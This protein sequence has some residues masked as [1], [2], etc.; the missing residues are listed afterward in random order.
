MKSNA[1]EVMPGVNQVAP[2]FAQPE[3]ELRSSATRLVGN[4]QAEMGDPGTVVGVGVGIVVGVG[5]T[6]GVGTEVGV[7]VAVGAS[8][9]VGVLV[10]RMGVGVAVGPGVGVG[11]PGFRNQGV[12]ILS[13]LKNSKSISA[14]ARSPAADG[15]T[16]SLMVFETGQ[17]R[18][19]DLI[20]FPSIQRY[21]PQER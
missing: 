14:T 4:V 3:Q 20:L 7:G 11:A 15:W 21:G 12:L 9:G 1:P 17:V 19:S 8:V 10:G 18:P 6:V 5:V 2:T 16:Q 13:D